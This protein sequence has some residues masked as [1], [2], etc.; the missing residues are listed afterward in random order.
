MGIEDP[1]SDVAE[2]QF[3]IDLD[4]D[5]EELAHRPQPPFEADP[6]DVADQDRPVPLADDD[7]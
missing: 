3:S 5:V 4:E 6:A 2:Q 1:D 7:R